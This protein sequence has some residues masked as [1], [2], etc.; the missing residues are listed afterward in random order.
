SDQIVVA[1]RDRNYPVQYILA[2][3][4]GHGFQRPVNNMALFA[5]AEKFL[6][7]YLKGRYQETMTDESAKRL[8]EIT[9]DP[10]TVKMA[11]KVDASKLPAPKPTMDLKAE[12][13]NYQASI[14]ISGQT[15]P[16]AVAYEVKE[17]NGAWTITEDVT[18]PQGVIKEMSVIEKG[19]LLPKKRSIDQM[20]QMKVELEYKDG[21]AV[22]SMTMGGQTKPIS[23][24]L[25]GTLFADG[26]GS[27]SI[28]ATLPL[29]E[30][31]ATSFRNYD[32]QSNKIKMMMLKVVGME[33]VKVPAGEF[34]A[35]KITLTSDDGDNQ[36]VW[37]DKASRKVVKVTAVLANFGGAVLTSELK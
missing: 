19:T 23:A 9:I 17:E 28:I 13:L 15:I 37:I 34:D 7:K 30:N 20:G 16:L 6:A 5:E 14:N 8:K 4:E 36:V 21:K 26:T 11:E 29:A 25:G 22:G 27:H 24:D 35:Y 10:K 2:D 1:L 33:K 18:T 3:D 32:A 12:K 31:Y